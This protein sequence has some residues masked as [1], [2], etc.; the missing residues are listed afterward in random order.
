MESCFISICDKDRKNSESSC[1]TDIVLQELFLEEH[2]VHKIRI[3]HIRYYS[4]VYTIMLYAVCTPNIQESQI[5][6]NI[7]LFDDDTMHT[8]LFYIISFW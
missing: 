1:S 8:F 3:N 4:T 7:I 6:N 2:M 5:N